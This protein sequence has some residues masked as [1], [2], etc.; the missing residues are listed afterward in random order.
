MNLRWK[1]FLQKFIASNAMLYSF[2][3]SSF[4]KYLFMKNTIL[5]SAF[6]GTGKS[7][8]FE[9]SKKIVLDSDS[10]KFDKSK[11]PENYIEHIKSHIGYVDIICISSHLE[12]R[13]ALEE[14]NIFFHLVYPD[15]RSKSEYIER[16]KQRGSDVKFI[17]LISANWA[18]W[19]TEMH[20]QKNCKQ[21]VLNSG[22]FI[23]DLY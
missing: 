2:F 14:N 18:N 1:F 16:Y 15:I 11:F 19:L 17:S 7:Y 13:K 12:V 4:N 22:Q 6:P 5:I 23:S 21:V 10:S 9:N 8:L 3:Y 20:N